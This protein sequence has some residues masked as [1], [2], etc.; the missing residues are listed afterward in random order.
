MK[1][2]EAKKKNRYGRAPARGR[3]PNSMTR[4]RPWHSVVITWDRKAVQSYGLWVL[5][6]GEKENEE[7][8]ISNWNIYTH[9]H[10]KSL[11]SKERKVASFSIEIHLL[12]QDE[13][14]NPHCP[15]L[16]LTNAF[17]TSCHL[18]LLS[19]IFQ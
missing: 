5:Q 15:T 7:E 1:K 16:T 18:P 19:T 10:T 14:K 9:A 13:G 17:F 8:D 6:S 11:F 12:R 3:S 2:R 4:R